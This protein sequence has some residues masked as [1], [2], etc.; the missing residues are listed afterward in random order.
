MK[1]KRRDQLENKLEEVEQFI[2]EKLA[3]YGDKMQG[4]HSNLCIT[5]RCEEL[6]EVLKIL[7][8]DK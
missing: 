8:D 2:K 7:K 1:Y 6:E 5:E 3:R 4:K